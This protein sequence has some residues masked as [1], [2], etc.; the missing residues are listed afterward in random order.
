MQDCSSSYQSNYEIIIP[1]KFTKTILLLWE[2][3]LKLI[4]FRG[5]PIYF[6]VWKQLYEIRNLVIIRSL[7]KLFFSYL[8]G[9]PHE[10]PVDGHGEWSDGVGAVLHLELGV[11]PTAAVAHIPAQQQ[12]ASVLAASFI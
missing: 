9:D 8:A 7:K 11:A 4:R 10:A 6:K 2:S 5:K 1:Q 3:H 12:C